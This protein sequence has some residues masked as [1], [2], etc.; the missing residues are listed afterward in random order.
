MITFLFDSGYTWV[1][2]VPLSM[3]LVRVLHA[4]IITAYAAVEGANLIKCLL[5]YLFVRSGVWAQNL[6]NIV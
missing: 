2:S 6:T 4:D 3:L 1:L 5:G